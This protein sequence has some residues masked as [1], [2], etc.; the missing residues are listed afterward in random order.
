MFTYDVRM[1]SREYVALAIFLIDT[2]SI[3]SIRLNASC[4]K[5]RDCR[6]LYT[7]IFVYLSN[8]CL[9]EWVGGRKV[10]I[11]KR[12]RLAERNDFI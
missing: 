7:L 8:I 1:C 11:S 5:N 4:P 10:I 9:T 3:Q 2:L 6:V 12:D